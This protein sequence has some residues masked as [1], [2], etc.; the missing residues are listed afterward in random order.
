MFQSVEYFVE[1]RP[2]GKPVDGPRDNIVRAFH[3][4]PGDAEC[5]GQRGQLAVVGQPF[6]DSVKSVD[7]ASG[8]LGQR[9]DQGW[10]RIDPAGHKGMGDAP[11]Q[12]VV[13]MVVVNLGQSH[14]Q[15]F[16]QGVHAVM[17]AL[18][19]ATLMDDQEHIEGHL[20]VHQRFVIQCLGKQGDLAFIV[21]SLECF[22]SGIDGF[23]VVVQGTV[24]VGLQGLAGGP[25]VLWLGL[26]DDWRRFPVLLHAALFVF[27]SAPAGARVIAS[28]F[29][30][31]SF[32]NS[33]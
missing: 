27:L 13:G 30:P 3:Q 12:I 33:C 19:D 17:V 16:R 28:D 5:I 6:G 10:D 23:D 8:G 14:A 21:Q 2:L 31:A 22:P 7:I 1:S 9:I 15:R 20:A 29:H 18:F 32:Q 4:R 26:G 25:G 11:I 24:R